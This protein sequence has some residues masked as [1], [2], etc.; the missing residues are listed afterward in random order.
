MEIETRH[1]WF[2]PIIV[3]IQSRDQEDEGSKL[4]QANSSRPPISKIPN[5]KKSWQSGSSG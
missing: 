2:T 3:A 4:A 1:Q 5:T